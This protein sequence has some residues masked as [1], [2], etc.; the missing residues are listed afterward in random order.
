MLIINKLA[1]TQFLGKN[2][3]PINHS[4][5]A[6]CS[7]CA[8]NCLTIK[9]VQGYVASKREKRAHGTQKNFFCK[10]SATLTR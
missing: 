7:L 9:G 8:C 5:G 10:F 2:L 4:V 1:K 6:F 3:H